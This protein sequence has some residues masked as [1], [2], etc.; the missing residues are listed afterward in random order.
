MGGLGGGWLWGPGKLG[1]GR[2]G[3]GWGGSGLMLSMDLGKDL[4]QHVEWD[5]ELCD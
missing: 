2:C 5:A 3:P 4:H 1:G